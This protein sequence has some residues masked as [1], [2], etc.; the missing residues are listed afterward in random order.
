[1]WLHW[2]SSK[3]SGLLRRPTVALAC[4]HLQQEHRELG[5]FVRAT[6]PRCNTNFEILQCFSL[7]TGIG[8]SFRA[9]AAASSFSGGRE[10]PV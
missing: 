3:A 4:S 6:C 7:N 2:S 10:A 9:F 5:N 1:M 8:G